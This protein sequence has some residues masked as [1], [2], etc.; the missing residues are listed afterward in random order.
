MEM[1]IEIKKYIDLFLKE[2]VTEKE[3]FEKLQKVPRIYKRFSDMQQ[4]YQRLFID[5]CIGK[6]SFPITYD[7]VFKMIFD[8]ELH[9]ERLSSF[10]SAILGQKVIV[11]HILPKEHG[12]I[13]EKAS[14]VIMD[15][16]VRLEN[17][18][19]V[20]VE[21]QKNPYLFQGERLSCYSADL[22]M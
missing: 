21:I 2:T 14:F 19:I 8:P 17:G 12:Q 5:M 4:D 3:V 11:E 15:I 18:A 10:L 1:S 7:P 6:S 20:N 13:V 16:V 9:P 22:I